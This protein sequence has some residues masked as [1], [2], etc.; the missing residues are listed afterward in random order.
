M[1]QKMINEAA[2]LPDKVG[3][4]IEGMP[5]WHIRATSALVHELLVSGEKGE[6]PHGQQEACDNRSREPED[7][8]KAVVLDK[9]F[10]CVNRQ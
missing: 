6:N 1:V 7:V 2:T 4:R 8:H 3:E 5:Q 10:G 9:V